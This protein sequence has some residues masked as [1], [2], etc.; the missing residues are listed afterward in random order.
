MEATNVKN[1][2]LFNELP[3]LGLLEVLKLVVVGSGK[4]GDKR[5]VSTVNQCSTLASGNFIVN[6]VVGVDTSNII[7]LKQLLGKLVLTDGAKVDYRLL[8][9]NVLSTTGSIL[10]STTSNESN[11]RQLNDLIKDGKMLVFDENGVIFLEVI[12]VKVLLVTEKKKK[13]WLVANYTE[14]Q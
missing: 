8:R 7:G 3:V 9:E 5:T 13:D 14:N 2:G 1:L 12:L 6:E 4:V 11:I 10:G